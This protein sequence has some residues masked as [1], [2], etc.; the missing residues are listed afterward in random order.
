MY[1]DS[2]ELWK[3]IKERCDEIIMHGGKDEP[4]WMLTADRKFSVKSLYMFLVKIGCGFPHKFPWK[5]KVHA[6][7]K[8]FL[9]LINK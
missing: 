5:I 1:G 9:W 8:A 7:I 3:L 4:M 6:K 2:L